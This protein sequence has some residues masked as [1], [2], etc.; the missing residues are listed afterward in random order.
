MARGTFFRV[1]CIGSISQTTTAATNTLPSTHSHRFQSITPCSTFPHFSH[2]PCRR[3]TYDAASRDI[4]REYPVILHMCV[5]ISVGKSDLRNRSR[6]IPVPWPEGRRHILPFQHGTDLLTFYPHTFSCPTR[7]SHIAPY[8]LSSVFH[9]N[10]LC[11][12]PIPDNPTRRI[13]TYPN[14]ITAWH[15]PLP[16]QRTLVPS[17]PRPIL[18]SMNSST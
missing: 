13:S 10:L 16:R 8:P 7:T 4:Q 2:P 14:S 17:P 11:I 12:T 9:S 18:D 5:M 1:V 15:P 3:I 6:V